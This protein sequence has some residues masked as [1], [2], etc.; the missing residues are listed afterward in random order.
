MEEYRKIHGI[1]KV[2]WP[3][4]SPDLHP[5]ED[6]WGPEKSDLSPRWMEVRGAGNNKKA[7]ELITAEWNTGR[8]QAKAKEACVNWPHKLQKCVNAKGDNNFKG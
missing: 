7:R 1:R 3:A 4:N 6:I 8:L 2:D 5:I